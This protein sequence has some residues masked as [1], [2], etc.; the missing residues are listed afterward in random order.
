MRQLPDAQL[1]FLAG[2]GVNSGAAFR[3]RI[4]K[5]L[6]PKMRQLTR[7]S[8]PLGSHMMIF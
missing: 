6:K 2:E 8:L 4:Q 1:V 5:P 3:A 7:F